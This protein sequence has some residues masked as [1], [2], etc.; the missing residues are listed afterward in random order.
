MTAETEKSTAPGTLKLVGNNSKRFPK[1]CHLENNEYI[2]A[3]RTA[4]TRCALELMPKYSCGIY[5]HKLIGMAH[6]PALQNIKLF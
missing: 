1:D 3:D 6:L 4:A 5:W 2:P